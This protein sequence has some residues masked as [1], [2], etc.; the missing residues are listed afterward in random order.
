M[1][2]SCAQSMAADKAP[3]Q[4]YTLGGAGPEHIILKAS[5]YDILEIPESVLS[6]S[7]GYSRAPLCSCA[8]PQRTIRFT[9][10]TVFPHFLS[11]KPWSSL[12]G[13]FIKKID[14][15]VFISMTVI[16]SL[17]EVLKII[18]ITLFSSKFQSAKIFNLSACRH[19]CVPRMCTCTWMC[20]CVRSHLRE[21]VYA[22]MHVCVWSFMHMCKCRS[23]ER[24]SGALLYHVLK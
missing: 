13:S 5:C 18:Q 9:A 15:D 21:C 14:W 4:Y 20:V 10:Q 7:R 16:I 2:S 23:Q 3:W 17:F 1:D 12:K 19:E 24:T 8:G 22:C 6:R 11:V